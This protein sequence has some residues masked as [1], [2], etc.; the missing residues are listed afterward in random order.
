MRIDRE[1]GSM[2]LAMLL[3]L[4]G[5]M[6]SA[7]LVPMVI[8]QV[9]STTDD[10]HRVHALAAAQAGLD[11]AL[12]HIRAANDGSGNGVLGSLPCGPL[13]GSVGVG[14]TARYQV[15]I[16]YYN[17]DPRGHNSTWLAAHD[18]NCYTGGG[19]DS[20]PA[21]ALLTS[22]GTDVATGTIGTVPGRTLQGTYTFKTT[23]ANI[24]GGLIH[25]YKTAT[26]TDLCLD[27]G[28]GSPA[29]GTN[30]QMQPCTAGSITQKFAY[31]P[32]LNLVLVSSQT[33][34]QPLG[35]C[36]DAGTPQA[37]GKVVAFQP[38]ASTTLPQQQWSQNDGANFQ[39]TADG[40]TLD[41][42]C[43]NVQSPNVAGSFVI[44]G[45]LS[46][47]KCGGNYD[48]QQTFM[49]EAS[50]GAGAAGASTGQLVNFN[51]F[52]RCLDVTNQDVT[53]AY[54]IAWPC[55]QAPDPT[56]V[57][58][59]QKWALP[60]IATGA[61]SAT[62]KITTTKSP[63]AYCLRSPLSTVAGTYVDVTPCPSGTLPA[64]LTWTVSGDTGSYTTSYRIMDSSGYCLA[65]T[66]P[67]ASPPDLFPSGLLISKIVVVA[68]DGNTL[69]KW[70]APPGIVPAPPLKDIGEQ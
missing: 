22:Q 26:S 51:E 27:A 65:P 67:N 20:T 23:N 18:I 36:L 42:F 14:G 55:K 15:T 57:L 69:E 3:T 6:L 19:A 24:S 1:R 60:S 12:G 10:V 31:E 50:A 29:A 13:T 47:G 63:T 64:N 68:C 32:N 30:V 54:M 41:G 25:V 16:T 17:A 43:F 46:A 33:T 48:N 2:P 59:N 44:L 66:D 40:H 45:A 11:V 4:V 62:G 39:G 21:Y 7:L 8:T 70:N 35:M 37:A 28:S 52:G 38:C 58:W 53:Y 9:R 5:M 49:P 34:A 56:Y 61:S